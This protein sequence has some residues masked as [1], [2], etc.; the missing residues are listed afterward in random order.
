MLIE[1]KRILPSYMS[2]ELTPK[3]VQILYLNVIL[4]AQHEHYNILTIL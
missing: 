1:V 4:K 3:L 2:I